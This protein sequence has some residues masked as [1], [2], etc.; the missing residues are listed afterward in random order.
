MR[1]AL[2]LPTWV[3]TAERRQLADA[4]FAS[5]ARTVWAPERERPLLILLV[6]GECRYPPELLQ[7]FWT[8]TL[9]QRIE[10][11][12]LQGCDQPMVFGS[13]WA[14]DAGADYVVQLGDDSLFNPL[15]LLQLEALI[16]RHPDATAWSVYRS[17]NT[18]VHQALWEDWQDVKV[19]SINGN[20]LTVS[21]A[22]WAAW[23]LHWNQ[24][25]YW[26]SPKGTTLDMHHICHRPGERWVTKRS[27]LEHAGRNGVHCRPEIPEWAVD[28]VGVE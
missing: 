24:A 1:F 13:Q 16:L 6:K 22:E 27:Y 5:L 11:V 4:C 21:R 3:R 14:F 23:G 20:G 28:F 7:T 25:V 9:P 15:W 26:H 2:V 18:A 8:T 10:D 17:A 12:E 19:T